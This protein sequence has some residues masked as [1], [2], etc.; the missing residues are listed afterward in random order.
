M[1]AKI[2]SMKYI[3]GL[4]LYL[5]ITNLMPGIWALFFP[6]SFY[7][8]FPGMGRHWVSVDGPYNEHLTRDVGAFFCAVSLLNLL[9]LIYFERIS[10]LMA[11]TAT[12]VFSFFHFWYHMCHL[13]MYTAWIDKMGNIVVLSAGAL[14]PGLLLIYLYKTSKR[15]SVL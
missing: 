6:S 10:I 11:A 2:A 5:F 3:K 12:F 15:K 1:R 4:L 8:D 9:S 13:H 7:A 14:V